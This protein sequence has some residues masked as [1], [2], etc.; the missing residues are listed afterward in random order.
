MKKVTL[1]YCVPSGVS[2]PHAFSRV[3][4][5]NS[6]TCGAFV[7]VTVSSVKHKL[8]T[9]DRD[10]QRCSTGVYY[11][12]HTH[13]GHVD[14]LT[15]IPRILYCRMVMYNVKPKP[16]QAHTRKWNLNKHFRTKTFH[17]DR[18]RETTVTGTNACVDD[19][20]DSKVFLGS[21]FFPLLCIWCDLVCSCH[22]DMRCLYGICPTLGQSRLFSL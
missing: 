21:L 8:S 1:S 17:K 20:D 16:F 14:S 9:K 7:A 2:I 10:A 13:I 6:L 22:E 4:T 11:T 3:S 18:A 19:D 5:E 15:Y 12:T